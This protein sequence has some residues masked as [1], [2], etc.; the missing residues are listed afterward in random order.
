M[1][2]KLIFAVFGNPV[3]HSKSPQMFNHVFAKEKVDAFYTRVWLDDGHDVVDTMRQLGLSGAN[4]TSP[5]KEVV[6][7]CLDSVGEEAA[8]IGSVNTIVIQGIKAIGYNTDCYGVVRAVEEAGF[9][10][11][12]RK[13]LVLGAGGAGKAAAW[14]LQKAGGKVYIANHTAL[15]AERFASK[16]GCSAISM[17]KAEEMIGQFDLLV[18]TLLPD[19]NPFSLKSLPT[20]LTVL[21]AN[22]KASKVAEMATTSGCKVILGER[23][24]VHQA[25]L[26]YNFFLGDPPPLSMLEAGFREELNADRIVISTPDFSE[27]LNIGALKPDLIIP[28]GDK[29]D[30]DIQQIIHEESNKA[31]GR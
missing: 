26:A 17:A 24:L 27:I 10:I 23:W 28:V 12:N 1:S 4:I 5:F 11:A 21:D 15:K 7:N 29:T 14:G 9:T 31:F 8:S 16:I 18:S 2:K 20:T 3:L 30:L 19:V 22:Y 6:L 13:C 25:E